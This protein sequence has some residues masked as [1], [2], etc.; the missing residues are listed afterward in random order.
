MVRVL[1][2]LACVIL[3]VFMCAVMLPISLLSD[4][5]NWLVKALEEFVDDL[6][7]WVTT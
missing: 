7:E 6:E 5:L 3:V 2:C 4:F 1:K